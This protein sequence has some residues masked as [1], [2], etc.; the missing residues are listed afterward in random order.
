MSSV[1]DL[2]QKFRARNLN[3]QSQPF[4]NLR[5]EASEKD[6]VPDEAKMDAEAPM[7]ARARQA[8]EDTVGDGGPGG[9][10][11]GAV[12]ADLHGFQQSGKQ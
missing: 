12:K 5:F 7:Y 6:A 8:D 1:V 9:V 10:L 4:V 11:R 3:F 2:H